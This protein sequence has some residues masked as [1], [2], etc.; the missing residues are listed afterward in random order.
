[1]QTLWTHCANPPVSGRKGGRLLTVGGTTGYEAVTPVNL[2][3]GKHL[4]IIGTTM[5][6]ISAYREAMKQVF[7]GHLHPVIDA[8]YPLEGHTVR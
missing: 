8:V 5:G 4:S 2:V 6:P 1:M 7:A 3:F